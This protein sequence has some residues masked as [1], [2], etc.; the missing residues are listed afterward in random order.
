VARVIA[1]TGAVVIVEMA[2]TTA[3]AIT[4]MVATIA[5]VTVI[6]AIMNA[7]GSRDISR[8]AAMAVGA[9]TAAMITEDH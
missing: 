1:I 9:M 4:K 2:V 8:P 5:V 7:A 6:I 3:A